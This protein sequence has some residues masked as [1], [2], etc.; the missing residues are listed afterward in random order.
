M[1]CDMTKQRAEALVKEA[2]K[3]E[4]LPKSLAHPMN[5]REDSD[6][7]SDGQPGWTVSIEECWIS[8]DVRADRRSQKWLN[9]IFRK[10]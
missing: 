9:V 8:E 5:L 1:F 10:G 3:A 2:M 6:F 4:K 7:R